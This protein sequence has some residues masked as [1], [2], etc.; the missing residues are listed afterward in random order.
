MD[1]LIE[2]FLVESPLESPFREPLNLNFKF[3]NCG[4]NYFINCIRFGFRR[5][6][7]PYKEANHYISH[8]GSPVLYTAAY[9]NSL[10][11][12]NPEET[13]A[14]LGKN[15]IGVNSGVIVHGVHRVCAM[16]NRLINDQEYIPLPLG[17][18][19]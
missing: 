14:F 8:T 2:E 1:T 11:P 17:K 4:N 19:C 15:P 9:Y 16:I 10:A 3:W 6:V 13:K 12:M 7:I 18:G 5:G